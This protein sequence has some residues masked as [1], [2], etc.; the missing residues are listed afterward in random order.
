MK[1]NRYRGFPVGDG[2]IIEWDL[3]QVQGGDAGL[4]QGNE[5]AFPGQSVLI[6]VAPEFDLGKDRI[7]A[8]DDA[9]AILV[10]Y[11]YEICKHTER[12]KKPNCGGKDGSHYVSPERDF[13]FLCSRISLK[14]H[15]VLV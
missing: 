12:Y 14:R 3:L 5:F 6:G 11:P 7:I 15:H 2:L 13:F 1:A 10:P 4:G 8:V 9:I